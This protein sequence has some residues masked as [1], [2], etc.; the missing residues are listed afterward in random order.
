ML[1]KQRNRKKRSRFLLV[2]VHCLSPCRHAYFL[3]AIWVRL[4]N[5]AHALKKISPLL[6]LRQTMLA[7]KGKCKRDW[8]RKS[9][10]NFRVQS[11]ILKFARAFINQEIEQKNANYR[12]S[13]TRKETILNLWATIRFTYRQTSMPRCG[14]IVGAVQTRHTLPSIMRQ[15]KFCEANHVSVRGNWKDWRK[16][17]KNKQELSTDLLGWPN[18]PCLTWVL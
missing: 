4:K 9:F 2:S 3:A 12:E 13:I 16:Y 8:L 15:I 6:L 11:L 1:K 18:P 5:A 7:K 14:T 10:K 17:E